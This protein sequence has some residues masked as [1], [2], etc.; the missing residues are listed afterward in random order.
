MN[1]DDLTRG[2]EAWADATDPAADPITATEVTDGAATTPATGGPRRRVLAVAAAVLLVLGI[3]AALVAVDDDD[4]PDEVVTDSTDPTATTTGGDERRLQVVVD[5]SA[6]A[7]G[8]EA[9]RS[10][11]LAPSCGPPEA[12]CRPVAEDVVA[13]GP[14]LVGTALVVDQLVE[15]GA[16]TVR[17]ET[18]G[19]PDEGCGPVDQDGHPT[20]GGDHPVGCTA[21]VAVAEAAV[22]AV[23]RVIQPPGGGL[24]TCTVMPGER[25][26]ELT[27][28]SD[29]SVRPPLPWTCGTGAWD[30]GRLFGPLDR[31]AAEETLA[32]F[33]R[34]VADGTPTEIAT[35]EIQPADGITH[36][37]WRVVPEVDGRP[38]EVIRDVG[39]RGVA[40]WA[41]LR[42]ADVDVAGAEATLV[43]CTDEEPLS[44]ALPPLDQPTPPTTGPTDPPATSGE[45]VTTPPP[46]A[47]PPLAVV[48]DLQPPA[49]PEEQ[50]MEWWTLVLGGETVVEE[51]AGDPIALGGTRQ[52]ALV[53]PG[54]AVPAG[55]RLSIVWSRFRCDGGCPSPALDGSPPGSPSVETVCR[56]DL[57]IGDPV[58][59]VTLD[60]GTC[61]ADGVA[62]LPELT[63]PPAWSI[64]ERLPRPCGILGTDGVDEVGYATDF[65]TAEVRRCFV[66]AAN[67]GEEAELR[68]PALTDEEA[69][70]GR[71]WRAEEGVVT[72]VAHGDPVTGEGWT[73]RTC[74]GIVEIEG[75]PFMEPT[76]CGPVEVM[77]LTP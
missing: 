44:L 63:V 31:A 6:L 14:V 29:W 65:P 67:A 32:C 12:A 22:R 24:P 50:V 4:G 46:F 38:I 77:P 59:V 51:L 2:L 23:V 64:R 56:V 66:A 61:R 47:G 21:D 8:S 10:F 3:G 49:L 62:E 41:R 48:V 16:W 76:G 58:A 15:P 36:S 33:A 52:R 28:P 9:Y 11:S 75:A 19:C 73:T 40:G 34:A 72:V 7:A 26:G 20:L 42:C 18:D 25:V 53:A 1:D 71:S 68:S 43:D 17:F 55:E 35:S 57:P 27:V 74:D 13:A 39:L 37:W 5:A 30:A 69:V 70:A 60:G 54:V 45:P